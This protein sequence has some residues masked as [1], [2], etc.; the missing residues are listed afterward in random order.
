MEQINLDDFA[1][2]AVENFS[3]GVYL[4]T[5][6]GI[7][8][9]VNNAACEMIGYAK[10]ELIGKSIIDIDPNLT[11]KVWEDMWVVTQ[12]DKKQTIN[13]EHISKD[14]KVIPIEVVANYIEV[15]GN[16][17][18]CAFTRDIR[19]RLKMEKRLRQ[20]EKME[21]IG[22]LAGGIAHDFN[23]QLTGIIGYAE[24]IK[25]AVKGT[26]NLFKYANAIITSAGRS[27]GLTK[28]LLAFSRK[29][30]FVSVPLDIHDIAE[31]VVQI[32]RRSIDK[33]I[34]IKTKFDA[35]F[36]VIIGDPNQIQNSILNLAINSRDAM[37]SG[38]EMIISTKNLQ[39]DDANIVKHFKIEPGD[40]IRLTVTDNGTGMDEAVQSRIFEPLFTTKEKGLGTGMG[41]AA[42]YGTVKNHKGV[43]TVTSKPGKGTEISMFFPYV[44]DAD[45]REEKIKPPEK[46]SA[47]I[48][49]IEDDK[50]VREMAKSM[51]AMLECNVF[52]AENGKKAVE[53]YKEKYN[54]IDVV[55]LDV[56]MPELNGMDTYIKLK[57]IN[58]DVITLVASGYGLD[59]QIQEIINRGADEFIHKPFNSAEMSEKLTKVLSKS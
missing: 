24:L 21:A 37:P 51:L 10:K 32:L 56:I 26:P 12:N 43:I 22:Q 54:E 30:N 45:V 20:S 14:G 1:S 36:T 44:K 25:N 15:N 16:S 33:R 41:L 23:N 50:T 35:D 18:S 27:S 28:Q 48:L 13:T 6:Y 47:N 39:I 49:L 34:R 46:I 52:T 3:D 8:V 9:Y 2:F 59:S 4:L 17:Y 19:E 55:I 58:P 5:R 40:F 7:I 29:G 11:E 53:I 42:V 57:E 38:G 31:E